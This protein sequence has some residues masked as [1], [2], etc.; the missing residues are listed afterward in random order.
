MICTRAIALEP[1]R[2]TRTHSSEEERSARRQSAISLPRQAQR[3]TRSLTTGAHENG[4]STVNGAEIA[5]DDS[6][7]KTL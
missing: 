2:E 5:G 1:K 7:A 6:R 3:H 4:S